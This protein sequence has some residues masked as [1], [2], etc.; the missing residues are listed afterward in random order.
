MPKNSFQDIVKPHTTKNTLP[1]L[2][3]KKLEVLEQIMKEKSP[4]KGSRHYLWFVAIIA[5]IFMVFAISVLFASATVTVIPKS[6]DFN[7]NSASFTAVKDAPGTDLSYDLIVLGGSES[8]TLVASGMEDSVV[9]ATGTVIIYNKTTSAQTLSVNTKLEGSNNKI[10]K[11]NNKVIIPPIAG[12]VPGSVEVAVTADIGGPEYNSDPLDFKV[13][14]FKGTKKYTTIYGRSKDAL[15]GGFSGKVPTLAP[16]DT[17][18]ALSEL[19]KTLQDNLFQ[20]ATVQLPK[21]F[22]LYKDAVFYDIPT[23]LPPAVMD[24]TNATFTL[25]GTLYGFIFN[26][27]NLTRALVTELV[28]DDT[29]D[30]YSTN[31]GTFTFTLITKD[32]ATFADATK[33]NFTLTGNPKMVWRVDAQA[34]TKDLLAIDKKTFKEVLVKYPTITSADLVLRPAWKSSFPDQSKNITVTVVYPK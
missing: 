19:Q 32:A 10:Y 28:P 6:K 26:E 22:I 7:L 24:G 16:A 30:I 3:T 15:A 33:I 31:V 8:K 5:I 25:T 9:K 4:E 18:L 29:G 34:L 23:Q 1:E 11:I 21:G 27:K 12:T 14:G 17:T 2:K 13:V 20:K